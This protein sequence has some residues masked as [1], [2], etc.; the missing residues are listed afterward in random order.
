MNE[1][2]GPWARAK[3]LRIVC[4]YAAHGK[5]S[6]RAESV[7]DAFELELKRLSKLEDELWCKA[8]VEQEEEGRA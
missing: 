7:H 6:A 2:P 3:A 8:L 5:T 1:E 4:E